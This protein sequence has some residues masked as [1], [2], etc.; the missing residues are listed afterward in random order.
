MV[1]KLVGEEESSFTISWLHCWKWIPNRC[2]IQSRTGEDRGENAFANNR[3]EFFHRMLNHDIEIDSVASI[4]IKP[5]R[6]VSSNN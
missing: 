6:V 2:N 3:M 5:F 4:D 1:D